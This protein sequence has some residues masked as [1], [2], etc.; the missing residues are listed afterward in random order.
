MALLRRLC[1][2]IMLGSIIWMSTGAQ[3]A[4][5]FPDVPDNHWAKDAVAALAAKGLVEGYPDGTFKGDR[6][7]SRWET[8]M[9]VARLLSKMEQAQATFATKS[10]LEELRKLT[11]ALREELDALGVRV[12]NLEENVGRIDKR[13][14]ELERIT[15]YGSIEARASFQSYSNNGANDSNPSNPLINFNSAVGSATGAG[16][17]FTAGPAAGQNFNPFALGTFTVNNLKTGRPLG[18]GTGFTAK[19]ILGLN[20]KVSDDVDAGAEFAAFVSQGNALTDLYYG[21]SAPY[22]SN[23]FTAQSTVTGGTAGVQSANH[24]PFTRMTLDHFWVHH[25]PSNTRLRV[26]AFNDIHFDELVYQKQYNPGA[27]GP[28]YLD[29]YGFQVWETF[30]STRKRPAL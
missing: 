23:A 15:F 27:F 29:S 21:A 26:G 9:I 20:I 7:A 2:S 4:P 19:A 1:L 16:G 18:N 10:E 22:L 14:T 8:A 25:K 24:Q 30:P 5:L 11:A 3:A 6:A 13:V 28:K 12:D 17:R